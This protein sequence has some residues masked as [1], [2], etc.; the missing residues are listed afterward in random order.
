MLTGMGNS[1]NNYQE[2][3]EFCDNKAKELL[4]EEQLKKYRKE[5]FLAKRYYDN[6]RDLYKEL[7]EKK[8]KIDSRYF[9]PYLLGFAVSVDEGEFQY[10]QVKDIVGSPDYDAD[11]SPAGK[12]VVQDYLKQK[13]GEE[14]FAHVGTFTTLGAASAA[15]DILR[16]HKIDFKKSNDFT[17]ALDSSLSWEENVEFLKTNKPELY[18]FYL[19]N[20]NILD[21]TPNFIDKIRQVSVH[22]GGVVITDEPL[23]KY[24]PVD[25]VGTEIVTAF[26]ESGAEDTLD[27]LGVI[28]MDLLGISILDVIKEAVELIDEELYLIEEDNVL[29]V[30]PASYIDAEIA[31]F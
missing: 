27:K 6:G 17:T 3:K 8:A 9:I 10:I 12:P 4:N 16:I 30:V 29:K 31:L 7:S 21:L 22:A 20:K 5:I 19:E 14:H 2:L 15:K 13:Y 1:I 18:K 28:K 11:M 25:R 26:P 23:Y 24:I